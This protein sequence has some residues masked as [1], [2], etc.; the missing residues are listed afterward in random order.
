MSMAHGVAPAAPRRGWPF[1]V[2][3]AAA[4]TFVVVM[5]TLNIDAE[6]AERP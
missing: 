6:R 5:A 3:I 2:A 4:L 1:D